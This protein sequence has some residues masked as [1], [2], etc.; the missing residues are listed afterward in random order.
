MVHLFAVRQLMHHHHLH[1]LESQPTALLVFQD[2]LND[3]ASVEVAAEEFI[4]WWKLFQRHHRDVVLFHDRVALSR[5][6]I[7]EVERCRVGS[8]DEVDERI[9]TLGALV[10]ARDS[11][12]HDGL[13]FFLG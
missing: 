13:V 3:L 8:F 10:Q 1:K 6:A 9:G 4:V 11:E 2:E 7:E 12:R 5:D